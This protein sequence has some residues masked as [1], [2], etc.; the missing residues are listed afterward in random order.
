[1]L[2]HPD[3]ADQYPVASRGRDA[4]VRARVHALAP[5]TWPADPEPI[6]IT[7]ADIAAIAAAYE[8][9][10]YQ[11]PV[12][13]GHPATDDP[14]WGWVVGASAAADG[15]WL[16]V[17]LLPEMADLVRAGRYRAVS[18]ALWTPQAPGN[19]KPGTW[20][21]KHLGYLGA[22]A[23]A[24]KGLA[25]TRLNADADAGA[26]ILTIP[27]KETRNMAEPSN[28][29]HASGTDAATLAERER[30]LARRE[31]AIAARERELA[32][33]AYMQEI[34]AHV[35]A[36]RVLAAERAGLVAL[37]EALS[38]AGTVRLAE[39]QSAPA[40]DALRGFLA[41]LPARVDLAERAA[42]ATRETVAVPAVAAGYRMS[43]R[44]LA[45]HLAAREYM[46]AHP[47]TDYLSAVRAVERTTH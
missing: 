41:R 44:G 16:D 35:A 46:A 6:T 4:T 14:A 30:E 36:G 7:A 15:L 19:P 26:V 25:P 24:V 45:L 18:V 23:P 20:A 27:P 5:G 43:E 1:M 28:K 17:E 33:A 8:P 21:L 3:I 22:A 13:I 12:V 9:A 10:R 40:L 11:A 47:G 39:G 29:D 42:P 34:D 31:A 32:R 2:S 37:M 38:V